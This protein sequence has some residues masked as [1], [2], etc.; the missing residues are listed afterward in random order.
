LAAQRIVD[1]CQGIHSRKT[2]IADAAGLQC[3]DVASWQ[4]PHPIPRDSRPNANSRE[5][6]EN[7]PREQQKRNEVDQKDRPIAFGEED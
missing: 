3:K 2:I 4:Q 7:Q 1:R 5:D 6:T